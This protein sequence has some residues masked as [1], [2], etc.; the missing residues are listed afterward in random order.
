MAET[1]LTPRMFVKFGNRILLSKLN[2]ICLL[3]KK[4]YRSKIGGMKQVSIAF[5]GLIS[6]CLLLGGSTAE[7][8]LSRT[9]QQKMGFICTEKYMQYREGIEHRAFAISSD[10][11][12]CGH[13]VG[14]N[15]KEKANRLALESCSGCKVIDVDG[16]NIRPEP[17][18]KY[19]S[20]V[21]RDCHETFLI[22]GRWNYG[23]PREEHWHPSCWDYVSKDLKTWIGS[24]EIRRRAEEK[25][26]KEK[27]EKVAAAEKRR[28]AEERR[29][30]EA[31]RIEAEK[32]AAEMKRAKE[33]EARRRLE[34]ERKRKEDEIKKAEATDKQ[35]YFVDNLESVTAEE[36][37]G[38][39]SEYHDYIDQ[40]ARTTLVNEYF[41]RSRD[42]KT[43]STGNVFRALQQTYEKTQELGIDLSVVD[44]IGVRLVEIEKTRKEASDFDFAIALSDRRVPG[45][46][47][48]ET[49]ALKQLIRMS[50]DRT[51]DYLVVVSVSKAFANERTT[52]VE[53]VYSDY[54]SGTRNNPNPHY[55]RLELEVQS[56]ASALR[57][58][59]ANQN[60]CSSTC[61]GFACVLCLAL[62]EPIN[63]AQRQ[64]Q[65]ASSR[66]RN[67]PRTVTETVYTPYSFQKLTV[68][69]QKEVEIDVFVLERGTGDAT[70]KTYRHEEGAE[71]RR[72]SGL[73]PG[74]RNASGHKSGTS[75]DGVISA[76][77]DAGLEIDLM[78]VLLGGEEAYTGTGIAFV[79]DDLGGELMLAEKE[80]TNTIDKVQSAKQPVPTVATQTTTAEGSALELAFWQAIKDSD[81]PDMYQEYLRQFPAGLYSGLA[82]LK[83]A[84]LKSG[85]VDSGKESSSAEPVV[86]A[87][88]KVPDLDYGKYY[89]LIIGNNRYEYLKPLR[90]AVNDARAVSDLLETDY[91]FEVEL[92]EDANRAQIVKSIYGL[93]GKVGGKDNLL[94][95]YAG[96]GY[97]EDGS[98][99]GYWLPV[100][101]MDDDPSNWIM[102]DRVVS[103]IRG[104]EAKHV[105]VVADSCFSGTLTRAIKIKER[106]PDHLKKMVKLKAR[107]ALT[108]GGLEPVT[109]SLRGVEFHSPFAHAFL[110]ILRDN[111]GVL[112]AAN[113]YSELKPKVKWNSKQTP[114]YGDIREAGHDGGDFVFVR[115]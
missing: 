114:E 100:D 78:Q 20:I 111:N 69:I 112:E 42:E 60:T 104:M 101:A 96:H 32:K 43:E 58:A 91:G 7:A 68:K 65:N 102:T 89:A 74:D 41:N 11:K 59:Q 14:S 23:E 1:N 86:V 83:I 56:A 8:W 88:P 53:Q 10:N 39:L 2:L 109:D 24:K 90:T 18:K 33:D 79:I 115:Q 22:P 50:E 48:L 66:L 62:V 4:N 51:D 97:L 37:E 98:D 16:V 82:K 94:I 106:T 81:D 3:N 72:V 71:F 31:L 28:E 93:R 92:L 12:R 80:K 26:E 108:S 75:P 45:Q 34:A 57:S 87:K 15:S 44:S 63:T 55:Q 67:T 73:R 105:M 46:M 85:P 25:R 76:F 35:D 19:S 38:F 30:K 103:Q 40:N 113:L 5:L 52:N 17:E 107:T 54:E 36:L 110:S 47:H 29:K 95:Y 9:D 84:K 77:K 70:K 49:R 27:A 64:H 21:E 13:S 99:E 61:S 6:T